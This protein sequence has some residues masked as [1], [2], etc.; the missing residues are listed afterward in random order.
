MALIYKAEIIK[1]HKPE[2]PKNAVWIQSGPLGSIDVMVQ[3]ETEDEPSP[4]CTFYGD[5]GNTDI[6]RDAENIAMSLGA[7]RPVEFR[8]NGRGLS[9][10]D[11]YSLDDAV[12][13]AAKIVGHED[14]LALYTIEPLGNGYGLFQG[15]TSKIRGWYLGQIIDID[16]PRLRQLIDKANDPSKKDIHAEVYTIERHGVGWVIFQGRNSKFK[17]WKLGRIFNGW[18]SGGVREN[19]LP[20]RLAQLIARANRAANEDIQLSYRQCADK[21]WSVKRVNQTFKYFIR[22]VV[23]AK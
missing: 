3:H 14:Q 18:N 12:V 5:L 10:S 15:Q 2:I 23:S 21:K 11:N 9:N 22:P 1:V 4:F 19:H 13:K 16:L 7:S 8:E 20:E 6:R 17:G